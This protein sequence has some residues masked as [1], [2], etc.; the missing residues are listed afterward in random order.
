MLVYLTNEAT[1]HLVKVASQNDYV[2]SLEGHRRGFSNFIEAIAK[3]PYKDARPAYIKE[4][5][6]YL[7]KAGRLPLWFKYD[8][9]PRMAVK[10]IINNDT[11]DRLIGLA[12]EFGISNFRRRSSFREYTS[13]VSAVLEAIGT[14]WLVPISSIPPRKLHK[15]SFVGRHEAKRRLRE[16]SRDARV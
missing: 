1:N 11:V 10:I 4:T 12:T 3:L 16:V 14:R 13:L 2:L 7:L 9:E 8:Y 5:D 6:V 15:N